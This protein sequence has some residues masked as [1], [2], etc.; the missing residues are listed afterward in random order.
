MGVP[1]NQA[2]VAFTQALLATYKEMPKSTSFLRSFF[3]TKISN[4]RYV[5][6]EVQRG[7]EK[8]ASD[9][10]RGSD[11][12]RNSFGISTQ[13]TF[14]PPYFVEYLDMTESMLYD[15][16]FGT[17]GLDAGILSDLAA[18]TAENTMMM[19][20]KIER[21]YELMC[22]QA[23]VTG[24]ITVDSGENVDFKRKAGSLVDASGST[25]ATGT[26]D[27]RVQLQNA[28]IWLRQNGKTQGVIYN[29]IMGST[30]KAAFDNNDTIN[31]AGDV[32]RIDTMSIREPQRNSIGG[33]SHGY[34]SAGDYIFRIWTYGEFYDNSSNESTPYI[35]PKK[36]VVLPEA[37]KFDM[38]FAAVPRLIGGASAPTPTDYLI[39]NFT[40]ERKAT[41]LIE[42]K[43]AGIP[44]ITAVDQVYTAQVIA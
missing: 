43:S 41:D 7:T 6:I 25:W 5:S 38:S 40:D 9:V 19:R 36:I 22:A 34:I 23:L 4:S 28:A 13:K 20:D 11:G 24:I 35:D 42:I 1:T 17:S 3:P 44:V 26:N 16:A 32:L 2:R 31:A 30:A 37:P 18:E 39:Q 27:P 21:R 12:N 14:D 10:I 33:T 29:V 8:I 15:R